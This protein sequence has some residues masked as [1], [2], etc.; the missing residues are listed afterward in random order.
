MS[1]K[2]LSRKEKKIPQKGCSGQ[3][4]SCGI[5]GPSLPFSCPALYSTVCEPE[6]PNDEAKGKN[7]AGSMELPWDYLGA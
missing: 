6:A 2:V 7:R 3:Q 4:F 5:S 1:E